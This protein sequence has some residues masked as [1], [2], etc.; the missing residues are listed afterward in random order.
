MKNPA[1]AL[2]VALLLPL[3]ASAEELGRITAFVAGEAKQWFTIT[4]TQGGRQVATASFEQGARLTELRVQGHP[5]PSFSTRDVFSLDVRYEGPF[6]PGAVPLS[7][8][9]MHVPEGMGGPF[10]TSRN[11]GKPAQVDIV[12][13][14]VWGSYG[15]LVATFEAELCFRP[16][17]SSA[18][19]TG[20]CR[21]VTGVIETEIS[22]E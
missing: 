15:R 10:W 5:G 14:E 16:I 1:R 3:P 9:V 13:L 22:V 17:I 8:D 4:M 11:A 18:T 7:V 12:E 21:A 6:T 2:I 19:D 20:N